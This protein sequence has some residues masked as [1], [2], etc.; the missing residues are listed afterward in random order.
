MEKLYEYID[1]T[2]NTVFFVVLLCIALIIFGASTFLLRSKPPKAAQQVR[3]T[4]EILTV[5][6]NPSIVKDALRKNASDWCTVEHSLLGFGDI[7]ISSTSE[8]MAMY[9]KVFLTDSMAPTMAREYPHLYQYQEDDNQR[10]F[11]MSASRT[12]VCV[13]AWLIKTLIDM[14]ILTLPTDNLDNKKS[15]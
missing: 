14:N 11:T 4:E 12:S 10:S 7:T 5:Q 8:G 13:P 15:H 2:H 1:K 3:V 6:M 9:N